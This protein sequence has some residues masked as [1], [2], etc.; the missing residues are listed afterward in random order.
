MLSIKCNILSYIHVIYLTTILLWDIWLG[1][2]FCSFNYSVAMAIFLFNI[3]HV[4]AIVC[5]CSQSHLVFHFTVF[6]PFQEKVP[7]T[8]NH[9]LCL[10]YLRFWCWL[11]ESSFH[12]SLFFFMFRVSFP[13]IQGLIYWE[14]LLCPLLLEDYP[15][16]Y[17]PFS[18]H[19]LLYNAI[20]VNNLSQ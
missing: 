14:D 1:S 18:F 10:E 20:E 15:C 2:D 11:L 8:L 6:T 13:N 7:Q 19:S 9:I 12:S 17:Y 4:L 3:F 16:Y 5:V